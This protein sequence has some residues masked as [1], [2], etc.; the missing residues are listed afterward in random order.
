MTM[1]RRCV[2]RFRDATAARALAAGIFTRHG[3]AVSH[4]L[5]RLAQALLAAPMRL[6]ERLT[7]RQL[8]LEALLAA[9]VY[10]TS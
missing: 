1:R 8:F 9:I 2:A 6:V 10:D 7:A 5:S 3:S 4:Q